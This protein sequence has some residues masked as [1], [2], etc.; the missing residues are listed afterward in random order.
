[1]LVRL[2]RLELRVSAPVILSKLQNVISFPVTIP[3]ALFDQYD[4]MWPSHNLEFGSI[5]N[6]FT[7]RIA[8]PFKASFCCITV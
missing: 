3:C 5:M 6:D 8:C 2:I 4:L 1:M 7:M